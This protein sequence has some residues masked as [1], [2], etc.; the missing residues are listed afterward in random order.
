MVPEVQKETVAEQ[1]DQRG[2]LGRLERT[3]PTEWMEPEWRDPRGQ[4]ATSDPRDRL[5]QP[6]AIP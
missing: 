1:L 3:E 2:R 5:D 4:K 6:A